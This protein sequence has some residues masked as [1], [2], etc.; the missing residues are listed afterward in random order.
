M[1]EETIWLKIRSLTLRLISGLPALGHSIQP[2]NSEK[3]T[4]NGVS[5]KIDTIRALLQQLDA[6]V[7]S[8]KRF[9]ERK[10]QVQLPERAPQIINFWLCPWN[11]CS[12]LKSD[13]FAPEMV[14]LFS[15]KKVVRCFNLLSSASLLVSSPGPPTFPNSWFLQQWQLPVSNELVLSC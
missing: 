12:C 8:G 5:S 14:L 10:I 9:L 11:S 13:D 1:E 7:N 15:F 4:E 2:K 3:T 6:A